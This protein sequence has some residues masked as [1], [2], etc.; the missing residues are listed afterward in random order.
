MVMA[1]TALA[2]DT[3]WEDRQR[4]YF[5]YEDPLFKAPQDQEKA[6]EEK[7]MIVQSRE[8]G[9]TDNYTY[10]DL[11]DLHPDRF[12]LVIDARL[13]QCGA[14]PYRRKC[15]AVFRGHRCGQE[16]K[17]PDGQC[18]RVCGHAESTLDR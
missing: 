10:D 2:G 17:P 4:G 14:S 13:K 8:D 3:F 6:D 12:Q 15:V 18:R 9:S 16:E 7:P 11:F 5:W 1:S